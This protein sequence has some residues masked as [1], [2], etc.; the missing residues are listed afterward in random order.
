MDAVFG[1]NDAVMNI[2]WNRQNGNAPNPVPYDATDN[3][4]LQWAAEVVRSGEVPGIDAVE[5]DFADFTVERI[6]SKDD[7]PPRLMIA[8]KTPFG[9]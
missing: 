3:E 4:I 9:A 6:P 5:V 8:P 1:P 7:L 2:T